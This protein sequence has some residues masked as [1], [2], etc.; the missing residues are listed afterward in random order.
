M[1]LDSSFVGGL[2]FYSVYDN[3]LTYD[4]NWLKQ[5][6]VRSFNSVRRITTNFLF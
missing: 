4:K 3:S 2:L 5:P 1:A 6:I